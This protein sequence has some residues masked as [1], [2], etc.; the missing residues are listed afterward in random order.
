V[1][2]PL[3][4][5]ITLVGATDVEISSVNPAILHQYLANNNIPVID[6]LSADQADQ[7]MLKKNIY[8]LLFSFYLSFLWKY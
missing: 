7:V 3:V 5:L 1:N 6:P 2:K 4:T 8:A